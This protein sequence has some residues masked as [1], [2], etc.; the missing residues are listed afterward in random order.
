[1]WAGGGQHW[2]SFKAHCHY[3]ILWSVWDC[4]QLS[5][6]ARPFAAGDPGYPWVFW[7][8][9]IP[10]ASMRT[11]SQK[12][13]KQPHYHK[14]PTLNRLNIYFP[15]CQERLFEAQDGS[16]ILKLHEPNIHRY[17]QTACVHII[18]LHIVSITCAST[19]YEHFQLTFSQK[20]ISSVVAVLYVHEAP[21][22]RDMTYSAGTAQIQYLRSRF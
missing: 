22:A 17:M 2:S 14:L 20:H 16:S 11:L 4:T 10:C 15:W 7:K 8:G 3:R 6:K 12:V 1:M 9:N 18:F 19:T 21:T 13:S 5:P